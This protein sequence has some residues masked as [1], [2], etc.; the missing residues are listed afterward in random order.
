MAN[1]LIIALLI[2]LNSSL[3]SAQS[4]DKKEQKAVFE[5][6]S[7]V[8]NDGK[9]GLAKRTTFPLRRTYPVPDIKNNRDF[10]M[11][12]HKILDD[13]LIKIIV[14]SNPAKDWHS[15]GWRGIMLL[16]GILW[17][18]E[19]GQLTAVNYESEAEKSRRNTLIK[20][21]KQSLY[22]SIKT[23][24]SPVVQITTDSLKI[25]I[26]DL[27]NR[28]YRYASWPVKSKMSEKPSLVLVN[29][30]NIPE[31]SG[32]NHRFEFKTGDYVYDCEIEPM[33]PDNTP[34]ASLVVYK[35]GKIILSQDATAL[36]N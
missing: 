26:D 34:P 18:D 6:I 22:K 32:E 3:I 27:G 30:K 25:R 33:R 16:N 11:R 21:E 1:K 9:A 13:S 36:D 19:D 24:S 2:L 10:I 17:L 23:F 14:N 8:K 35:N 29:G 31:G 12:Y 5:F 4:L 7:C 20:K 15:A 28:N